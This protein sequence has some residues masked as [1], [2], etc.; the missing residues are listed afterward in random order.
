MNRF[1]SQEFLNIL[2]VNIA[3]EITKNSFFSESKAVKDEAI[4]KIILESD[5]FNLKFNSL[6][7]S[8]VHDQDGYYMSN[9]LAKSKTLYEFLTSSKIIEI[10]KAYLGDTFRLKCHRVYSV[11]SGVKNPWHTDDKKYGKKNKNIKG[12]VFIVYLNDVFDGE[13]Q[14]VKGSHLISS[15]FEYPNFNTHIIEKEFKN[16]IM[17]FKMPLGSLIIFDNKTIHRA[18]PYLDFFWKRQSLFFQIDDDTN[19]G[20]KIL[21]NSEFIDNF[22]KEKMMLLGMGKPARMP[23]EPSKTGMDTINFKMIFL[24]QVNLFSAIFKRIYYNL[25]FFLNDKVKR[26]LQKILRK[27]VKINTEK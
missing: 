20:E 12:L 1:F 5:L 3:D 10:S 14:A 8:S 16:Q 6:E 18:K 21:I 13:F 4:N 17:T 25:K 2:S 26:I 23:H 22:D 11:N 7:V 27:K 15:K 9:G 24:I 19:D